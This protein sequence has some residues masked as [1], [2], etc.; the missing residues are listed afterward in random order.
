MISMPY[1]SL[2]NKKVGYL[3]SKLKAFQLFLWN[4]DDYGSCLKT[5]GYCWHIP[6]KDLKLIAP[7]KRSAALDTRVPLISIVLYVE[8]T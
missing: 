8:T 4:K 3:S 6:S 2:K 1:G 7:P 5:K